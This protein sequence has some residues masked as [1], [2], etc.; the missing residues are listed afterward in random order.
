MNSAEWIE[1]KRWSPVMNPDE[2]DTR[3]AMWKRAVERSL[4][5]V[6]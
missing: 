3:Y 5:W 4:G 1:E 2:R 6:S